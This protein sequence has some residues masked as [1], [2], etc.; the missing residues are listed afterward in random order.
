MLFQGLHPLSHVV[1]AILAAGNTKYP[2]PCVG[3]EICSACHLLVL[4]FLPLENFHSHMHQSVLSD[5]LKGTLL[6]MSASF[7]S[8]QVL[9]FQY[10]VLQIHFV[11]LS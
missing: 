11:W 1:G 7:L 6:Q 9:L 8:V 5:R 4:L 10:S 3:S 2:Q